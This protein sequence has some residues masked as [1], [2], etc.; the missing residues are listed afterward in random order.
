MTTLLEK[1]FYFLAPHDCI[2]C[3]NEGNVVCAPCRADLVDDRLCCCHVCGAPSAS[4][5]PCNGCRRQTTLDALFALGAH[6]DE[7]RDVI[8][9]L[10]FTGARQVAHD[11]APALASLLPVLSEPLLITHMPTAHARVRAR[12]FDHA[13]LL[14]AAL[15]AELQ[16]HH[17]PLLSRHG[18]ARQ[19]G[20]SKDLRARQA[21][22]MFSLLHPEP[23]KGR[24]ILLVDDVVTTGASM[25]AAARL[26][27]RAG[28]KKVFGVAIARRIG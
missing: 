8:G 9:R 3:G 15:A 26:I 19:V 13:Q 1:L 17:A 20:A 21:K 28:A 12:G 25:E 24:T 6:E 14:A 5:E 18:A 22:A 2:F 10:K 7:L 16:V 4:Y 23:V 27:Q 11:I